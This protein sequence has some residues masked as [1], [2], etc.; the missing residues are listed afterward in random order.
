MIL[1]IVIVAIYSM[2]SLNFSYII[3]QGMIRRTIHCFI[4]VIFQ[5]ISLF[6]LLWWRTLLKNHYLRLIDNQM[7]SVNMFKKIKASANQW[8]GSKMFGRTP[9]R[10]TMKLKPRILRVSSITV[11]EDKIQAINIIMENE[12]N[13]YKFDSIISIFENSIV[14]NDPMNY[15]Y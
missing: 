10:K 1:T 5:D 8:C 3:I 6:V 13:E 15:S 14:K 2:Y 9:F 7:Y 4:Y 11:Y 12:V